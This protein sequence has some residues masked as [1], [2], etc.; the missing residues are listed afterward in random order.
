MAR[1]DFRDFE[2][3]GNGLVNG[4]G[5]RRREDLFIYDE[6]G[7]MRNASVVISY[8]AVLEPYLVSSKTNVRK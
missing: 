2:D 8:F 6:E 3:V 1:F 5:T 7:E 4:R